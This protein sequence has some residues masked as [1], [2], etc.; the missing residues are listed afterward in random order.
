MKRK[1]AISL[2]WTGAVILILSLVYAMLLWTSGRA[3]ERTLSDYRSEGLPTQAG[4][5]I[6][7][8]IPDTENSALIV[9]MATLQLKTIPVE[10]GDLFTQLSETAE[11]IYAGNGTVEEKR[12]FEGLYQKEAVGTAIHQ[13]KRLK[14]CSGWYFDYDYSKGAAILLPDLGDL[15]VLTKI[16]CAAARLE[17]QNGNPQSA[18]NLMQTSLELASAQKNELFLISQ[19]VRVKQFKLTAQTIRDL[20]RT[21]P[22][23]P[24]LIESLAAKLLSFEDSAPFAK[25]MDAERLL[26]GEWAFKLPTRDLQPS[27]GE[28][29]PVLLVSKV[30]RRYDHAV[31]LD[32]MLRIRKDLRTPYPGIPS[33]SVD[34]LPRYAY[35]SKMLLPALHSIRKEMTSMFAGARTTRIGLELLSIK[36]STGSYPSQLGSLEEKNI[37]D[38]FTANPLIYHPGDEDF[39]LYSVG[40]NQIDGGGPASGENATDDIGW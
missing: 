9:K 6:P 26:L 34:E 16:L 27:I 15:P 21:S 13:L 28:K 31:Y 23:S 22:P 18:W 20:A 30:L 36:Q 32:S 24:E 33:A 12:A 11:K 14:N 37:T 39:Q 2:K 17:M 25:A 1:T 35:L 4:E 5:I 29:P 3:L 10:T 7:E 8:K 40:V 38:P 19:L